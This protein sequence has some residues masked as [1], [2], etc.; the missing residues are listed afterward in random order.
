M[1]S[2]T[3][4]IN[5]LFNWAAYCVALI[6][7]TLLVSQ[8][9]HAQSNTSGNQS[10]STIATLHLVTNIDTNAN[11]LKLGDIAKINASTDWQS[12]LSE[13]PLGPSPIVGKPQTLNRTDIG[14]L[15][16]RRGYNPAQF[17]WEGSSDC[18]ITRVLNAS[19]NRPISNQTSSNQT[20]QDP[21]NLNRL[22]SNQQTQYPSRAALGTG[23][24]G[25][26]TVPDRGRFVP[27]N[28]SPALVTQAER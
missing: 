10:V 18:R 15:L 13:I 7:A 5:A 8:G 23:K 3:S 14:E 27:T 26:S 6:G 16:L 20:T 4:T 1:T 25:G 28:T 11:L 17:R 12:K 9:V 24:P 19:V 21:N 22:A 2:K